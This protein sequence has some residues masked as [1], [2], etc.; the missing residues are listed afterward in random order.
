MAVGRWRRALSA[1][2]A[3]RITTMCNIDD[4][5]S[6]PRVVELVEDAVDFAPRA[7][8]VSQWEAEALTDAVRIVQPR[9]SDELVRRECSRIG[10]LSGKLAPR[11]RRWRSG[12]QTILRAQRR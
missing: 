7:A 1:V 9:P 5:H 3:I 6:P 2:A 12:R 10:Q 4:G 11:G 8:T